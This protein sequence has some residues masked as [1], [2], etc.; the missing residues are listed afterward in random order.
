[1]VDIRMCHELGLTAGEKACESIAIVAD[2]MTDFK[3]KTIIAVTA[4]AYVAMKLNVLKE[5]EPAL[6][7]IIEHLENKFTRVVLDSKLYE[8]IQEGNN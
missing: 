4:M 2:S 3:E 7:P 6:A 5:K 8:Q 1:M